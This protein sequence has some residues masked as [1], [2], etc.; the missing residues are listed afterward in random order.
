LYFKGGKILYDKTRFELIMVFSEVIEGTHWQRPKLASKLTPTS[1]L[2]SSRYITLFA[3]HLEFFCEA[4]NACLCK[5][6][7][8]WGGGVEQG[9]WLK[10]QCFYY[11]LFHGGV[12][13]K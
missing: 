6:T 13:S 10:A 2:L 4:G 9:M 12:L 3:S 1:P 11:V 7:G 5:L 8:K